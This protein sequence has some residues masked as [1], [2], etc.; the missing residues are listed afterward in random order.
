MAKTHEEYVLELSISNSKI[1]VIETYINSLTPILHKCKVHNYEWKVTPANI[2]RRDGCPKCNGRYRR[3][4]NDYVEELKVVNPNLEVLGTYVNAKNKILHRC[5][6]HNVVWMKSPE[7]ALLGS[8]CKQCSNDILSNL[9]SK[10][11]E[12]YV[13]E[14][15][16]INPNIEVL[17]EYTGA[18]N[19]ILHRCKIDKYEWITPPSSLL[20]G[21][22]CPKCNGGYKRTKD[23]YIEELK[24]INPNIEIVSEFKNI[25][26]KATFR[27]RVCEHIWD[28]T[29]EVTL[30]GCGCPICGNKAIGDKLR[31]SHEQYIYELSQSN[32]NIDVVDS[33]INSLT[34]I[35]HRCKIHKYEWKVSPS[36]LLYNTGCP[37]CNV[38]K[39][40]NQ[41]KKWIEEH[42]IKFEY[43]KKFDDCND[44]RPLPFDFYL[45]DYNTCIEYD[46]EQHYKSINYF[47]GEDGLEVRQLHDKIKT[48]Y[49]ESKGIRLIRIPYFDDVKEK[50]DLLLT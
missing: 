11:H 7:H 32:P 8:G 18:A 43:Q 25:T 16:T 20:S 3:T 27:C 31:K 9:F 24:N 6:T 38:S 13:N 39:G 1:E 17:E 30:R 35:R 28:T 21:T 10:T 33:Y 22:G 19:G 37:L 44:K 14:L 50:L 4:H 15:N 29:P 45:P 47:G 23:E 40:E 5:K 34:P 36:H 26:T 41:V 42:N 2:L 12:E 46:G 48:E 49:C